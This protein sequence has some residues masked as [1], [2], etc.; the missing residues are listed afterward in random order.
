MLH[1][2]LIASYIACDQEHVPNGTAK[3]IY[4]MQYRQIAD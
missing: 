1:V 2:M 3:R 4:Q